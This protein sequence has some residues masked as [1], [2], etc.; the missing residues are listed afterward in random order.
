MPKPTI[1][2]LRAEAIKAYNDHVA[3]VATNPE[4]AKAAKIVGECQS[5]SHATL[6]RWV[7]GRNTARAEA[8]AI[9][10]KWREHEDS[11]DTE[12]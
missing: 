2:E 8:A 6:R 3:E 9:E 1:A 5:A 10:L 12:N 7:D 11:V 4:Y